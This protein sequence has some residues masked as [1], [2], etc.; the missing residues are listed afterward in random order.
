ME[1]GEE[2]EI[3]LLEGIATEEHAEEYIEIPERFVVEKVDL[4]T[5]RWRKQNFDDKDVI[6]EKPTEEV[7]ILNTPLQCF[8]SFF[9][10][11]VVELIVKESKLYALQESGSELKCTNEEIC[12]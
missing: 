2:M 5:L 10:N 4:T 7:K 1:K 9:D 12:R 6:W 11:A 8:S 3:G